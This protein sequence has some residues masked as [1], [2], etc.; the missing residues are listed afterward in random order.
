[1]FTH[2]PHQEQEGL[3][4]WFASNSLWNKKRPHTTVF[5]KSFSIQ[6]TSLWFGLPEAVI[7]KRSPLVL[8]GSELSWD[9]GPVRWHRAPCLGLRA[10]HSLRCNSYNFRSEFVLWEWSLAERR[11]RC[12]GLRVSAQVSIC[13]A[14]NTA[15]LGWILSHLL[16]AHWHL[17]PSQ[18]F[19]L[20]PYTLRPLSPST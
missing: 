3:T 9:P 5:I 10:R 8:R 17:G 7:W 19:P 16:S 11:S 6:F 18:P 13:P 20:S 2:E 15:Q 14:P 4:F 1:M 12:W